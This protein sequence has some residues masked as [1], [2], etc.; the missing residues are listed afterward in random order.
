MFFQK[1]D[2]S[3]VFIIMSYIFSWCSDFL[4]TY[5][6]C[7]MSSFYLTFCDTIL[8][9]S[10][11]FIYFVNLFKELILNFY[12]FSGT[13]FLLLFLGGWYWGLN[14]SSHTCY[15]GTLSLESLCQL[16][17]LFLN[18]SLHFYYLLPSTFLGSFLSSFF[19]LILF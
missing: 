10:Q 14:S 15:V 3:S 19:R 13:Y 18:F 7:I 17:F 11:R 2:I 6:M 5:H 9:S 8:F 4:N 12:V 1:I 16:C